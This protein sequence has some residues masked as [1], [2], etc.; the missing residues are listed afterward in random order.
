MKKLTFYVIAIAMMAKTTHATSKHAIQIDAGRYERHDTSA[1]EFQITSYYYP[2]SLGDHYFGGYGSYTRTNTDNDIDMT[3]GVGFGGS[4]RYDNNKWVLA[5]DVGLLKS[6][7]K[8][9]QEEFRDEYGTLYDASFTI[10]NHIS[11]SVYIGGT[12]RHRSLGN[13]DD[14]LGDIMPNLADTNVPN[15]S[16]N[17]L[18]FS[19][20][21]SF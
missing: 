21:L 5:F 11:P 4:Y 16:I 19:L 7:Q 3:W 2:F 15:Q 14:T 8:S 13:D 10:A 20:G 18:L 6:N 12:L 1:P 17:S 9:R